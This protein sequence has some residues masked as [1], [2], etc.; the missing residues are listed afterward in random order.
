MWHGHYWESA[1]AASA[2]AVGRGIRG[3]TQSPRLHCISVTSCEQG[4][5]QKKPLLLKSVA[6][7]VPRPVQRTREPEMTTLWW[8]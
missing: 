6:V 1:V 3:L 8:D 4:R 7:S 5:R 2:A